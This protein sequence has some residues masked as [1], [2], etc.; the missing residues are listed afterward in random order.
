MKGKSGKGLRITS[1]NV[2]LRYSNALL[3]EIMK[4]WKNH[5]YRFTH[6][7]YR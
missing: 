5:S 3:Y 2:L 7:L 1:F 6:R 4:N